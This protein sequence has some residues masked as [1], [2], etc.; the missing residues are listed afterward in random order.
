MKRFFALLLAPLLLL[1]LSS[2]ATTSAA[3]EPLEV[4]VGVVQSLTGA[5]GVYG[6]TVVQGIDLAVDQINAAQ[7]DNRIYISTTTMDDQSSVDGAKLAYS[8]LTDQKVTAIIG[9]TLSNV[10]PNALKIA[11]E[12]QVVAIAPT[13]TALGITDAGDYAFNVALTEDT[14]VPA[15]IKAVAQQT[16]VKRAVLFLDSTDAFSRGSA[17]AM[18]KGIA[19]SGGTIVKEVDVSKE[20]DI[21]GGLSGL[22]FDSALVTPLL[23]KAV[24]IL[25]ALRG[26]GYMQTV[27]GGNSFNTQA[28]ATMAGDAAEGAYV[29]AAWNAGIMTPQNT[30]FVDAYMQAYGTAP[31]QYAAQGYASVQLLAAAVRKANSASPSAVRDALASLKG[32][33]TPLGDVSFAANRYAVYTPVVQ[34][35]RGGQLTVLAGSDS[36]GAV[37]ADP[38]IQSKR[39]MI[40]HS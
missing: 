22:Q 11:Q 16:S 28:I 10:A 8:S 21:T 34:Q 29:G 1:A 39:I 15:T 4:D 31:D 9:P 32:V 20:S 17:D 33:S 30:R 14:V 24:A 27:I 35:Y 13:T 12:S 23:D 2:T 26:A 19:A 25:K 5:G 40:I 3:Q 7:G 37:K 38:S 18:R 6:K 36:G